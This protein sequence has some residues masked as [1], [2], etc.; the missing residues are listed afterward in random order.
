MTDISN[1]QH[2]LDRN[3]PPRVQITYDVEI[4]DAIQKKELPLVVGILAGLSGETAQALPLPERSFVPIDRDNFN[5]VLSDIAPTVSV[6]L[7]ALDLAADHLPADGK[8]AT[9]AASFQ[10]AISFNKI[11]D[12]DP[13]NIVQNV[14]ELNELNEFRKQLRYMLARLDG[15]VAL[16]TQLTKVYHVDTAAI[17]DDKGDKPDPA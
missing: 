13:I 6:T 17:T 16:E 4:G 10:A 1:G 9:V 15:N 11:E 3:R 8:S 14:T 2:W 5:Q 12:F 7:P